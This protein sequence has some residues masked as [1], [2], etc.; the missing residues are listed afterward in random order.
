MKKLI[1]STAIV[2]AMIGC[3]NPAPPESAP[4]EPAPAA[5]P[6]EPAETTST[7]IP[8]RNFAP[9]TIGPY[10]V[11][12]MFEEEIED[13]HYNIRVEEGDFTAVRIWVGAEDNSD[14][15][16]V[17]TELENDYQHGHLEV[18]NPIPD[19]VELWI[20]IENEAGEKFTGSVPLA[21]HEG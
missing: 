19:G 17:K 3:G 21:I 7:A 5:K 6:A 16:V 12:P 2:L 10:K 1:F 9:V 20:E 11:Q 14:V 15:M 13:G 4:A 8:M 18:P